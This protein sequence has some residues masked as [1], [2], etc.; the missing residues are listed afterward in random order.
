MRLFLEETF[1]AIE[2][3]DTGI[4]TIINILTSKQKGKM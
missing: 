3:I 1:Y 4:D 2:M